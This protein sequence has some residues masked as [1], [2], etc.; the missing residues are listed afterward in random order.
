M[1]LSSK[2]PLAALA[3]ASLATMALPLAASADIPAP[4][5]FVRTWVAAPA[6]GGMVRLA[7]HR[8]PNGPLGTAWGECQPAACAWGTVPMHFSPDGVDAGAVWTTPFSVDHVAFQLSPSGRSLFVTENVHFTDNS[9]RAD[10][11]HQVRL[12]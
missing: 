11:T 5:A 10:Y 1:K 2:P 9:G 6:N 3:A 7:V 4:P 8:S 12:R